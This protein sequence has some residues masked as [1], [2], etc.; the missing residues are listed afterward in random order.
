MKQYHETNQLA[1]N[2][3]RDWGI[4]N[5][6]PIDVFSLTIEKMHNLTVILLPLHEKVSGC[7]SKV[8]DDQLIL[9]NSQHSKGRQNFTLAHELYHL[10]YEDNEEWLICGSVKKNHF[11][12]KEADNFASSLLMPSGAL[13]EYMKKNHIEKWTLEDIIFCEQF[14]QISHIAMLCKLRVEDLIT[15][16]DFILYKDNV[17]KEALKLGFS[18]EL[19]DPSSESK[20]HFSFG[21]YIRLTEK[22]YENGKISIGKKEE[23]LLDVFRSDIVYNLQEGDFLE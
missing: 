23:L 11:S 15:Y 16:D 22:A 19:Y 3:R 1:E 12:E 4:D 7:S 21:N 13:H 10:I 2:L 9:I 8:N 20:K 14:F 18:S 17:K 6:A 5:Y